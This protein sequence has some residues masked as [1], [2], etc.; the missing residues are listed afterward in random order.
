[1]CVLLWRN[2]KREREKKKFKNNAAASSLLFGP[3]MRNEDL[4][5]K[6]KGTGERST[7][8]VNQ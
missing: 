5:K 2:G 7:E 8:W 1:M 3:T 6:N 4:Q